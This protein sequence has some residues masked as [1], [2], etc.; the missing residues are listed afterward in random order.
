[1]GLDELAGKIIIIFFVFPCI[2]LIMYM[3]FLN[4]S[5][6]VKEWNEKT[7]TKEK[8]TRMESYGE[9]PDIK[10]K[11][12]ET[13]IYKEIIR[14]LYKEI[15]SS[16]ELMK[17]RIIYVGEVDVLEHYYIVKWSMQYLSVKYCNNIDK[18]IIKG[19]DFKEYNDITEEQS[20]ALLRSIKEDLEKR[21]DKIQ[22]IIEEGM[23]TIY[24]ENYRHYT[25]K[26]DI[27]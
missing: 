19:F 21:F 15:C 20:S 6:K 23:L 25:E 11:W 17:S 10:K 27:F 1:M 12:R 4:V 5:D 2:L 16:I 22:V 24:T 18:K 9:Y 7:E 3:I 13:G 26:K 8:R 14:Y